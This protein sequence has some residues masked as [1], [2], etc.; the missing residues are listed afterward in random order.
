MKLIFAWKLI[1]A[2][3][4]AGPRRLAV[5]YVAVQ[6]EQ[7]YQREAG[8]AEHHH[9]HRQASVQAGQHHHYQLAAAPPQRSWQPQ[10][11]QDASLPDTDYFRHLRNEDELI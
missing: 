2:A 7:H 4:Q 3:V 5:R 10:E 1:D 9:R 11:V 6:A 8:Q